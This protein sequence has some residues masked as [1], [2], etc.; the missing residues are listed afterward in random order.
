M[1][2]SQKIQIYIYIF[3]RRCN[4]C[5]EF[6]GICVCVMNYIYPASCFLNDY[7]SSGDSYMLFARIPP[8]IR[9]PPAKPH[10]AL[11]LWFPPSSFP[12]IPPGRNINKGKAK[13][14]AHSTTLLSFHPPISSS[15]GGGRGN[16]YHTHCELLQIAVDGDRFGENFKDGQCYNPFWSVCSEI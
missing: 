12:P 16:P 8:L 7:G 2:L 11:L 15:L 10:G 14:K 4:T 13:G 5:K 1:Y 3:R 6:L 9:H